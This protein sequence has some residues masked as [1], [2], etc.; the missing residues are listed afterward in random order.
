MT[1]IEP[2]LSFTK[3]PAWIAER[4]IHWKPIEEFLKENNRKK[5]IE[6]LRKL[7]FTG[8]IENAEDIREGF[9]LLYYPLQTAE[10]W[11]CLFQDA[12]ILPKCYKEFFK[13]DSEVLSA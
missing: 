11:D 1:A 10:A 9:A 5:T 3:H 13:L 7:F 6:Q 4:E 2:D 12:R 8:E